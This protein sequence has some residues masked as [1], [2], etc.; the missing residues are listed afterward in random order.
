[1]AFG[2]KKTTVIFDQ[3]NVHMLASEALKQKRA[4]QVQLALRL[5][6][7]T[8][9]L[10]H[11]WST[12]AII[13]MVGKM[14]GQPQPRAAK[15]LTEEYEASYYRNEDGEVALPC[16]ILKA[17]IVEGAIATQGVTTKADLK[18]SLRVLGYTTPLHMKAKMHMDARIASNNG[19]PDMRA[20][21][22]IPA[23]YHFDIVVQFGTV[24]TPDQV[25]AAIDGAGCAI[26]LCDFRPEKGGDFGTFSIDT[27]PDSEI[28]RILNDCSSPEEQYVI[29]PGFLHAFK[30]ST[31]TPTSDSTRKVMAVVNKVNG[32]SKK[33]PRTHANGTA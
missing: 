16:R 4:S 31:S 15:D 14:V 20:R 2:K 30:A 8:P 6:G 5:T 11:R 28:K 9:L 7:E 19:T 25:I 24:L 27:L 29:P 1:M 32:E 33:K 21:A 3:S 12:K 13:E 17:A 26:G 18:R 23:G 10:M 22:I